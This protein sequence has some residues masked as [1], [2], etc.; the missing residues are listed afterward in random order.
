VSAGPV[1]FVRPDPTRFVVLIGRLGPGTGTVDPEL[2]VR[3]GVRA[4]RPLNT[5][6]AT[7]EDLWDAGYVS[8]ERVA[9][10]VERLLPGGARRVLDAVREAM[11]SEARAGEV[12]HA[13][14]P[15][16]ADAT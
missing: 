12:A 14:I 16:R 7:E 11:A 5:E 2:A 3:H 1:T 13:T 9:I 8:F 10:A 15:S 4:L 6:Y